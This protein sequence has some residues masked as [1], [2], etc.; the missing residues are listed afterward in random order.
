MA[1]MPYDKNNPILIRNLVILAC[2]VD[3]ADKHLLPA[4][5]KAIDDEFQI[6]TEGLATF[7][8]CQT[9]A[10]ACALPFW[11]MLMRW[12]SAHELMVCGCFMWGIVTVFLACTSRFAVQVALRILMG[13]ALASVN[14]LGQA[15]LCDVVRAEERGRVF[16]MLQSVSCALSMIVNYGATTTARWNVLGISGWR[17]SHLA[18]GA[19]S[20]CVAVALKVNLPPRDERKLV[21]KRET[22][23][24][25]QQRIVRSIARK[26]SFLI[27]V[28]QGVTGSVPWNGFTFLTYYFQ[29]SGYT[30]IQAGQIMLL[31][32]VGGVCGSYLGGYLGDWLSSNT[33]F[34]NAGRVMVA[35]SSVILGTVAFLHVIFIPVGGE[36][37]YTIVAAY[38][39]F[40]LTACWTQPAA[41]RPICGEIFSNPQDRAQILSL[42]IALE[43]SI[44]SI[45]GAPLVSLLSTSFGFHL[46]RD[47]PAM[48]VHNSSAENLAE[49]TANAEALRKAL[50]GI[51]IIPWAFCALAWCPMYYTYPRDRDAALFEEASMQKKLDLTRIPTSPEENEVS[52]SNR[53]VRDAPMTTTFGEATL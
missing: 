7:T 9:F 46:S 47:N 32:G 18:V 8:F 25:E 14:P 28:A 42:W 39:A 35:Q 3:T 11:G 52:E 4:T 19:L 45:C 51:S 43:G 29:L 5:F 24:Q 40:H 2:A 33:M 17:W 27:M 34:P 48:A 23:C 44:A 53:L 38:M 41:L 50:V 36:H 49:N 20:L 10:F 26:P 13:F 31:S 1:Q 15:I 22:C 12:K 21:E 30:D 16:G 6:G 37:F